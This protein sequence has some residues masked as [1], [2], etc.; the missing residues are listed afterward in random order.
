MCRSR[1]FRVDH[2]PRSLH[3]AMKNEAAV[4]LGRLGGKATSEA[5]AAASRLNG[6]KGGW[7]KGKPRK[8]TTSTSTKS[9]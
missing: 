2:V 3:P 7:P 8:T 4:A 5:K 1:R 9:C 6:K